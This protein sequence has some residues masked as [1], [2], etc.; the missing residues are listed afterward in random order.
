MRSFDLTPLYRSAIGFDRFAQLIE[1]SIAG[2]APSNY[3]PYNVE[4]IADAQ[5]RITMAV[6]G[7]A[8]D[9]LEIESERDLPKV[10]GRK[11]G[12]AKERTYL[13]RGL[14]M[15]DFEQRFRLADH[16]KVV[17]ASLDAGLLNIDLA[18]EIP[19]AMKPR[20]IVIGDD[21]VPTIER[22]AA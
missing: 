2:E 3:P 13:H 19:E 9:E 6:A 20:R 15:R 10:R 17:S 8:E 7:F 18:R 11:R 14:S 12:D 5:Y 21:N 22:K 16:V 4:R 1:D